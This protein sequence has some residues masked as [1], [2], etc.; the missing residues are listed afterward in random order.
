MYVF[1]PKFGRQKAI[2]HKIPQPSTRMFHGILH[3]YLEKRREFVKKST[4]LD[5]S[6]SG[7]DLAAQ[8]TNRIECD[9]GAREVFADFHDEGL[10]LEKCLVAVEPALSGEC[11]RWREDAIQIAGLLAAFDEV[12][13]IDVSLARRAVNVVRWCKK[14]F[15]A[16]FLRPYFERIDE[17][18]ERILDIIDS[19]PNKQAQLRTLRNNHNIIERDIAAIQAMYPHRFA[20]ETVQLASGGR[21]SK[22]IC[23]N[24]DNGGQ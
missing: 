4:D 23:E 10:E 19:S 9:F 16:L 7:N 8:F 18:C 3:H 21:P 1:D 11:G 12:D 14:S 22:I 5:G 15:L 20:V 6:Q 13:R 24:K 2:R 17:K